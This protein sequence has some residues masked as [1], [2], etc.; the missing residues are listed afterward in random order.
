VKKIGVEYLNFV[1]KAL[2]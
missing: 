1:L 2:G